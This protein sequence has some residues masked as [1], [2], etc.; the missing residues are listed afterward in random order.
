MAQLREIR[1][2]EVELMLDWRNAPTVRRHMYN[3]HVIQREDH[4]EWWKHTKANIDSEYFM[5]EDN[6]RPIGIVAFTGI[7]R[8]QSN[9]SWAFYAAPDAPRGTG[10]QMELL[11]LDYAFGELDLHKL[12]C[13]VLS[14]N[15]AVVRLHEKFGFN[16]EGTFREQFR[17]EGMFIDI[18]RLGILKREWLVAR[19]A[20][21]EKISKLGGN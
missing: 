10:S 8:A 9:S 16:I 21:A 17:Q 20:L 1:D 5:Y 18:V 7:N 11:A 14:T 3:S 4:V 2:D 13:E 12:Y 19:P 15:H 6:E